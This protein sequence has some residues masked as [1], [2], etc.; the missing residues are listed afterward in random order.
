MVNI[1]NRKN[2]VFLQINIVRLKCIDCVFRHINIVHT[3]FFWEIFSSNVSF[4]T[5][6]FLPFFIAHLDFFHFYVLISMSCHKL[7]QKLTQKMAELYSCI[8]A[9][10]HNYNYQHKQK[11]NISVG[12]HWLHFFENF[13]LQRNMCFNI[14]LA[15]R[16]VGS[17]THFPPS[18]SWH[19]SLLSPSAAQ[20]FCLSA[21]MSL[22]WIRNGEIVKC[23]KTRQKGLQS[24]CF[25]I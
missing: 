7:Q 16:Q 3:I 19:C 10:T 13:S 5:S 4:L 1:N 8:N 20:L 21:A 15:S 22:S 18:S 25:P 12:E 23:L 24:N 11:E 14:S 17:L 9:C 2:A 6:Q